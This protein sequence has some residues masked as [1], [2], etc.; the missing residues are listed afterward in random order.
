MAFT[1]I[2]VTDLKRKDSELLAIQEKLLQAQKM[3]AIGRLAGGIA[4][5]FNNILTIILGNCELIMKSGFRDPKSEIRVKEIKETA[6]KAKDFI[7]Q[8]LTF[9]RKRVTQMQTININDLLSKMENMIR[10]IIGDTIEFFISFSKEPLMAHVDPSQIEQAIMNIVVNAVDA[11]P[12]GGKLTIETS[13]V[14]L[15]E[16]SELG[17]GPHVMIA[18]TDTGQGMSEGIRKRIFEPFFTTKEPGKG[19]GLGLSITHEIIKRSG[20]YIDVNSNPGFGS[21]FLIYLPLVPNQN[22]SLMKQE[23]ENVMFGSERILLVEDDRGVRKLISELLCNLG[24]K[25][26]EA[27]NP[28]EAL[29]IYESLNF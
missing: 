4:H 11:M 19:T 6:E 20:G 24:Y 14:M 9:S 29:S 3:G 23:D 10:R 7:A 5:H 17:T 21:T 22:G 26:I 12:N 28:M 18:I 15:G 8:L 16:N 1:A 13:S 25:V 2:D 27:G